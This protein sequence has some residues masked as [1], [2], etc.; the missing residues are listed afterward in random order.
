KSY[1]TPNFNELY[2]KMVFDGHYFIGNENLVPEQSSSLETNLHKT[3]LFSD[4]TITINNQIQFGFIQ[5]KD[6]ITSALVGFEGATPK[7]EYINISKYNN[8]N[9][10][11]TNNFKWQNFNFNL[12]GSFS[13]LSQKIDNLEFS[14]SDKY[15]FTYSL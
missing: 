12:G 13:W 8:L 6:R 1:R 15:L 2:S 11:S 5:I 3:T 9:I 14:T 10:A 7:Y 4:S